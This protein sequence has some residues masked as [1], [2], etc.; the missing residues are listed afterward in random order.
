MSDDK[1][2]KL[3]EELRD[4]REDIE[5]YDLLITRQGILLTDAVNALKGPPPPL[6]TWSHH[7]IAELAQQAVQ[8]RTEMGQHAMRLSHIILWGA[9]QEGCNWASDG[10]VGAHQRIYDETIRRVSKRVW[11]EAVADAGFSSNPYKYP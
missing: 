11:D 8:R 2:R 3:K 6:T 7:D 9:A 10:S 1:V 4:A 5:E